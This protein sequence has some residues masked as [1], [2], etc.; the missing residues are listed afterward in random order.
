L[1]ASNEHSYIDLTHEFS[2]ETIYWPTSE[3]FKLEK[4]FAGRVPEGF[5]YAANAYR[6]A[7]HGGTHMDAP[8]HFAEGR[9]TAD[10]VPL[11]N[12][13]GEA[14]VIDV[15][16]KAA[17]NRDYQILVEDLKDWEVIH[18]PIPDDAMVLFN[19]GFSSYWPDPE[20]YLGTARRGHEAHPDLHFPG[21]HPE[22][23]Q[24]LVDNRKIKAVGLDVASIDYGQSKYFKT[25]RILLDQNIPAFENLWH[26]SCKKLFELKRFGG[27][28][29]NRFL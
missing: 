14:I 1:S 24:W 23:A 7:E 25:H 26:S 22:A 10:E 27:R 18:G 19:T 2:E 9:Q 4:L 16:G 29:V 17:A 11:E 3:P 5:Y 6:A 8:I 15:T 21:L 20:K 28:P 13:I 12:L